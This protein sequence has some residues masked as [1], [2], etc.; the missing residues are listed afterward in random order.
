MT[1]EEFLGHPP[2][3]K[4]EWVQSLNDW[5]RLCHKDAAKWWYDQDGRKLIRNKGEMLMLM[6]SEL[7]EAMEGERKN[8]MDSH[9]PD[10]KAIEVELAD[11][12]IRLFDYA[13]AYNLDLD[14]AVWAKRSYNSTRKDHT[15]EERNKPN[16]KKW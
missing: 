16:G 5:A 8:L 4:V 9:L 15:L 3:N 12:L 6:V 1:E 14:G 2:S 10:R 11:L 13:G 7:S